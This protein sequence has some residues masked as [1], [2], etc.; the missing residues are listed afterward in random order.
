MPG[1]TPDQVIGDPQAACAGHPVFPEQAI[2]MYLQMWELGDAAQIDI[3]RHNRVPVCTTLGL[4]GNCPG[5]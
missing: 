4:L 2:V 3:P 1:S 5:R